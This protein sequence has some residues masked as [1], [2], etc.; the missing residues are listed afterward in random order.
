MASKSRKKIILSLITEDENLPWLKYLVNEFCRIEKAHFSINVEAISQESENIP[1]V[2]KYLKGK[3]STVFQCDKTKSI[4]D[5]NNP[6]IEWNNLSILPHSLSESSEIPFDIFWNAFYLLS[7]KHEFDIST[8]GKN[9]RSYSFNCTPPKNFKWDIPHVNLYFKYLKKFIKKRFPI[10][11]FDSGAK[12]EI[13]FSHDLDYIEKTLPLRIKQS[14]FNGLN[15]IKKPSLNQLF[16]SLKFL[17]V[18]S[19]Y[20]NFDYWQ[21]LEKSYSIKS[22]FYVYSKIKQ[23]PFTYLMDPSYNISKNRRLQEKLK[24][25]NGEGWEIGLHGSFQSYKNETLLTKEKN[26]LEEALGITI[27]KN[28]QHWLCYK[29][30]VTPSIHS[31]LFKEDATIG[32][33]NQMGFRAGIASPYHPYDHNLKKPFTHKILP[34]AIMDSHIYDYLRGNE[35]YALNKALSVIENCKRLQNLNFGVSWHPRT[36]SEDYNWSKGYD[37][38]IKNHFKS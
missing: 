14:F 4:F 5:S 12:S 33:N 1:L 24:S 9:I 13:T 31:N 30:S 7:R 11:E 25:L 34:Q 2:I 15:F 35:T 26:Q 22:V 17:T 10:L 16:H 29:E 38:L 21:E 37:F 28:R 32:W 27:T 19:E 6:M 8:T 20:W 36:S 23:T 18:K 3:N